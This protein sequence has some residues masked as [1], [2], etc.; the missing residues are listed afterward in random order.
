VF[1]RSLSPELALVV[2]CSAPATDEGDELVARL[3]AAPALNWAG[4][5]S[6]ADRHH[7]APRLYRTLERA[8]VLGRVPQLVAEELEDIYLQ[9]LAHNLRQNARVP[10]LV[11][12]LA[13][14]GI[15]A[16]LLKGSAWVPLVYDDAGLRSLGDVDVLVHTDQVAA[17]ARVLEARGFR[18]SDPAVTTHVDHHHHS[19]LVS[20]DGSTIVELHRRLGPTSSWLG[21]DLDGL[22]SRVQPTTRNGVR[23]L[24]PCVEDVLLHVALHFLG[25]RMGQ[26][27][28]GA[29]GQLADLAA[30]VQ[31]LGPTIDW[32]LLAAESRRHGVG[33]CVALVLRVTEAIGAAGPPPAVFEM[34]GDGVEPALVEQFVLRAVLRP[35]AW[36]RLEEVSLRQPPWRQLLPPNPARWLPRR[37]E[38]PSAGFGASYRAWVVA[39]FEVLRHPTDVRAEVRFGREV[40]RL[41]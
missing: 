26:A 12:A 8:G 9:T 3:V 21:Y 32:D 18:T 33:R 36:C 25:D 11:D 2:A 28:G 19:P 13:A 29:L 41:S 4:A 27:V 24:V 37:V 5:I 39:A 17:A 34:L 1:G 6:H 38:E 40:S 35:P 30:I 15:D 14:E 16:V 7:V 31:T 22:W 10:V 23:C 20:A